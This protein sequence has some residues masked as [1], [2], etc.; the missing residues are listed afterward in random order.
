MTSRHFRIALCLTVLLAAGIGRASA[1]NRTTVTLR[2]DDNAPLRDRAETHVSTLL[3]E[4]NRASYFDTRPNVAGTAVTEIGSSDVRERWSNGPIRC[5]ET[6][7]ERDLVPIPESNE[8]EVRSIPLLVET[9]TG[10]D[11]RRNGVLTITERGR[12]SGFR[13]EAEDEPVSDTGTI[14]LRSA[15]AG[16]T[17]VTAI[18]GGTRRTAP[19]RFENVPAD[20]YAFTLRK[21]GYRTV[22]DT[23][24]TIR[25]DQVAEHTIDLTS[26]T[27]MLHI[28][29]V[30]SDARIV[31][32]GNRRSPDGP[33]DVTAGRHT[34]HV[35]KRYFVPWDTTLSVPPGDTARVVPRLRRKTVPLEVASH[36]SGATVYVNGD[37]VGR[38]P[39]ATTVGTGREYAVRLSREGHLPTA[40][41]HLDAVPDSALHRTVSLTGIETTSRT[42]RAQIV[43]MHARRSNG[44]VDLRYDLIG[45]SEET[46]GVAVTARGPA[47]STVSVSADTLRGDVGPN[48]PPGPDK[49][50]RW[51][52]SLPSGSTVRLH[53]SKPGRDN[54]L[55]YIVGGAAALTGTVA[56]LLLA[57]GGD[58]GGSSFPAPPGLPE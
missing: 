28:A 12:V 7:L 58:G 6:T 56:A 35:S 22:V 52:S 47:G 2:S 27:G 39:L 8:F 38:T 42:D 48:L 20:T 14:V 17:V 26:T 13:F 33:M 40:P 44:L 10:T 46:Y 55:Y 57:G 32:D 41:M 29:S 5:P 45:E 31:V 4:L 25:A 34:V 30:P 50:I 18:R 51:R 16:A 19:A 49:L 11:A 37:S 54:R 53:L 9:G 3:T 24:L 21:D 43:N 23:P 15:P 36:P 1:Q